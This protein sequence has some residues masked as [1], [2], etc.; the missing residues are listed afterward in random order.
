M[1]V[2]GPILVVIV[3]LLGIEGEMSAVVDPAGIILVFGFTLGALL[4]GGSSPLLMLRGIT[5]DSLAAAELLAAAKG[6]KLARLYSLAAGLLGSLI[7]WVT[8]LKGLDDPTARGPGVAMSRHTILYGL[9]LAFLLALP[10]QVNIEKRI[11][12]A[13]DRSVITTAVLGAIVAVLG[14]IASFG[15]LSMPATVAAP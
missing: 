7:A 12:D 8:L 4:L 13:R 6:W 1:R 2:V 3:I 10:L 9:S 11:A 5:P 15:L 14:A